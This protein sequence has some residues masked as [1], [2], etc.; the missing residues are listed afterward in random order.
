MV[1][2]SPAIWKTGFNPWVGKIPWRRVWQPTPVFLPGESPW[3]EEPGRLQSMG[4]QR[5]GHNLSTLAAAAAAAAKSFYVGYVCCAVLSHFSHVRL[6]ATLWTVTLQAPLS[7]GFSQQEYWSGWLCP[8]PG[9][10]PDPGIELVSL[11]SLALA[12]NVFTT[13]AP[14][15]AL[16]WVISTN[17]YSTGNDKAEKVLKY[18]SIHK[19]KPI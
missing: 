16:M 15:E 14:W 18:L 1:K 3:K 17:I 8:P 2:N 10:L 19:N 6:F 5:V 12:G 11:L 13:S 9:D 7:T 4:L